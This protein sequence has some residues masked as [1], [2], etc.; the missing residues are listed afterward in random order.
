MLNFYPGTWNSISGIVILHRQR[1]KI[2]TSAQIPIIL[3]TIYN[4][5]S[6]YQGYQDDILCTSFGVHLSFIS[7]L[8][9]WVL[10]KT[11]LDGKDNHCIVKQVVRRKNISFQTYSFAT[12]I[13]H[14]YIL[15]KD[16]GNGR[17]VQYIIRHL[18]FFNRHH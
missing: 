4:L 5:L 7:L 9:T 15:I 1:W 3:S 13:P 6:I 16:K 10:C 11:A 14:T 17:S 12:Q 2:R 18:L 8:H